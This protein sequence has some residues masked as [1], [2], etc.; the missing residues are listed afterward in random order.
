[1][2]G[3]QLLAQM[4]KAYDV[5]FIFGVPGDTNVPFYAALGEVRDSVTHVMARDERSAGYMADAYA[6]VS[7][8][9][10]V[11]EVPSGA[12]A[13]YALP[14]VAEAHNSSV[15]M[16][17]ITSDTPMVNEGRG[18][19]TELDCA[20][21]FEPV[22][23]ASI[24]VK[25]ANRIPEIMRRAFRLATTGKPGAVH[26][27]VPEDMLLAEVDARTVSLHAEQD[28]STFPAYPPR[29]TSN[30][31]AKL[32]AL[33]G[34]ARR[35]LLVV[36]GGVNRSGAAAALRS[37]VERN[38]VPAVTT[39]TG[40][41]ALPDGHEFSVGIVGDNGFHPHANRAMEES[42]LLV[43]LGC[44]NGSVVSIG[45]TFPPQDSQRQVVQVDIDPSVLG[46]NSDNVLSITSDARLALED[47]NALPAI[48]PSSADPNW[49]A[50]LNRWREQ[51]WAS[52]Q[53]QL[54]KGP[55]APLNPDWVVDA[56]NKRLHQSHL[57]FA[58]PGTAT[59]YLS[60]YLRFRDDASRLF[61]PRAFGG[62]GYAIPA[63]V[64]SWLARPDMRPIG[65]FGDG[66]LGMVA[67]ELETLARLRVPAIL[68]N[69]NN[70]CFGWIKALQ[71]LHGHNDYMSVDFSAQDNSRIARA[72]GLH[73]LHVDTANELEGALDAAFS[74]NGPIFL[75]IVVQSI[76]DEVP[77]VFS[78][79]KKS[80][81]DPLKVNGRR[82]DYVPGDA[83]PEPALP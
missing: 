56:F 83:V 40:Q 46:N 58:D 44:R 72:F 7:N 52:A 54:A 35:P 10:G 15:P 16:I 23:K 2:N 71:G 25:S 82:L 32:H 1:M 65:L 59:P 73:S 47:L 3:A 70:A 30:D 12:G 9:P 28:C 42:D 31:I 61:I 38:R 74:Y 63:V 26:V 77:P 33:I 78:W 27:A 49:I 17:V 79:M 5:K 41:Q 55:G 80:G 69:F 50:T 8:R 19:I 39:I 45:W 48:K 22:T 29:A 66:S 34:Q 4:L 36:G 57:I 64:G 18:V 67:G 6:R 60:R 13:M 62:L 21:L 53:A 76:A 20:K 14:P 24:L 11:I 75:D 51:F 81:L 43:Y 68:V 37:F